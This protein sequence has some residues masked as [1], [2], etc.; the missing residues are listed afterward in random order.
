M[1]YFIDSGPVE[2]N[3][4]GQTFFANG[5][6]LEYVMPNDIDRDRWLENRAMQVIFH[7][8]E[9]ILDKVILNQDEMNELEYY[10]EKTFE[11]EADEKFTTPV[12]D[13]EEYARSLA[14]PQEETL[15]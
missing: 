2:I 13:L 15:F 11:A 12:K 5:T 8:P 7:I 3:W 10:L 1:E 6:H 4:E 9:R 14:R